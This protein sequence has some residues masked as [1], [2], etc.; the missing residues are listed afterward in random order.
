MKKKSFALLFIL[1]IVSFSIFS[2]G[3]VSVYAE[4]ND[5]YLGGM[6]AG[7]SIYSDGA[8]VAGICDVITK[9]GLISPAKESEINV[10]D[11]IKSIDGEE[12]NTAEDIEKAIK[13]KKNCILIL[14]RKG[15]N[16]I[17]TIKPALDVNGKYKLGVYVKD[18][19]NGIGT[20]T[21]IKGNR[22]ASLGHPVIDETG[23]IMKIRGGEISFCSIT[24]IVKGERGHAGELKGVFLRKNALG[25]VDKN[26]ENGVYGKVCDELDY[27]TFNKIKIGDAKV[28]DATIYTTIEGQEPKEYKIQIVKVDQ[29]S[30]ET[31]NYVIKIIDEELISKTGGIVQGMSGSP[32]IQDGNLVGAVTHVFI[33][34]PLR[35]YGIDIDNM[36]NNI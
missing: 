11:V 23:K 8:F 29:F 4:D 5:I 7:F 33:N 12:V 27:S 6:P 34:D 18:C 26:L 3:S 22:F 16:V 17:K 30:H 21:F 25:I 15:E 9:D 28:G 2:F 36:I 35:G 32:I 20:I 24:G 1:L 19:I 31:K 14:D 10:G 13:D